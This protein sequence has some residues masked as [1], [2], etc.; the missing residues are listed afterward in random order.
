MA[1]L[2]LTC[3]FHVFSISQATAAQNPLQPG[4]FLEGLWSKKKDYEITKVKHHATN[5]EK[6]GSSIQDAFPSNV[7][8]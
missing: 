3:G 1:N 6:E 8:V 4:E 5:A 7:F 2:F